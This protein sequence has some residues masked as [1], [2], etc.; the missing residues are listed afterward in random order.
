MDIRTNFPCGCSG[1]HLRSGKWCRP[2]F[3]SLHHFFIHIPLSDTKS[4]VC[5]LGL[6]AQITTHWVA[7]NNRNVFSQVLEARSQNQGVGGATL[8][9]EALGE[10]PSHPLPPPVL[11]PVCTPWLLPASLSAAFSHCLLLYQSLQNLSLSIS[12]SFC[13][14]DLISS[15]PHLHPAPHPW[16]SKTPFLYPFPQSTSSL[17]LSLRREEWLLEATSNLPCWC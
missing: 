6:L 14:S 16:V 12:I 11:V 13:I 4:L 17:N 9:P 5:S 2:V 10:E 8:C 15:S 1:M 7:S 3:L